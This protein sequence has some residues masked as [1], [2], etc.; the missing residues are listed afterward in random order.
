MKTVYR[1]CLFVAQFIVL[2]LAAAF[3]VSVISPSLVERVRHAFTPVATDSRPA[4][5]G[6]NAESVAR[7]AP[8]HPALVPAESERAGD[9]I[10]VS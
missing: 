5:S 3:V 6:S 8:D 9:N 1:L 7:S 4:T 10:T 2:G